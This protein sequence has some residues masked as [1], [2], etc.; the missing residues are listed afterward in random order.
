MTICNYLLFLVAFAGIPCIDCFERR[1]TLP[2]TIISSGIV[3]YI[4]IALMT[5]SDQTW[6]VYKY[7]SYIKSVIERI[8]ASRW[9]T[10][11]GTTI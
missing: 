8:D 10:I 1:L 3:T 6:V 2:T 4:V 7:F 11:S 5:S 9:D